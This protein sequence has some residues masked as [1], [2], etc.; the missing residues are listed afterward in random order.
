MTVSASP[1]RTTPAAR[2]R[3]VNRCGPDVGAKCQVTFSG[4]SSSTSTCPARLRYISSPA[5]F[6]TGKGNGTFNA[7]LT[8]TEY[9]NRLV[10]AL[11]GDEVGGS[12]QAK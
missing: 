1:L 10:K 9:L 3:T 6:L 7:A 12:H 8:W 4:L 2:Y 5:L 11:A